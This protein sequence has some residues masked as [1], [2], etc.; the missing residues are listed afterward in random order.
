MMKFIKKNWKLSIAILLIFAMPFLLTRETLFDK[1]DFTKTGNIGDTV[2]GITAPF[3]G[4]ISIILLY[5]TLKEQIKINDN[6]EKENNY[7]KLLNLQTIILNNN[8][9][10]RFRFDSAIGINEGKGVFELNNLYSELYN[11]S[12]PSVSFD[13]ILMNIKVLDYSIRQFIKLNFRSDLDKDEKAEFYNFGKVY[14]EQILFFYDLRIRNVIDIISVIAE[15]DPPDYPVINADD[16]AD[17]DGDD[18]GNNP[19]IDKVR[20]ELVLLKNN[21][22]DIL[23][24]YK[25]EVPE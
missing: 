2:G 20:D 12:I 8:S 24:T 9:A 17:D 11:T 25:C 16:D 7:N 21:L 1:L 14:A 3:V 13:A 23:N 19:M 15:I 6:Q 22:N 4:L 18:D 10:F 5:L